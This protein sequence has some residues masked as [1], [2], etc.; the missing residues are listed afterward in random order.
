[1]L[2]MVTI[3]LQAMLGHLSNHTLNITGL[4]TLLSVLQGPQILFYICTGSLC[5]AASE[6]WIEI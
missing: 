6:C 4:I 2:G 1:M 5:V 3:H